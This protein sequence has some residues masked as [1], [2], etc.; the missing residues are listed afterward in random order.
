MFK[1]QTRFAPAA[2]PMLPVMSRCEMAGNWG[3]NVHGAN[4]FPEVRS[5]K[6]T[7][8]PVADIRHILGLQLEPVCGDPPAYVRNEFGAASDTNLGAEDRTCADPSPPEV[9]TLTG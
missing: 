8:C 9:D 6:T 7:H 3:D 1:I 5:T 4:T 2:V